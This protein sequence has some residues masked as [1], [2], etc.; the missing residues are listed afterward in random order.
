MKGTR[1][2]TEEQVTHAI[3]VLKAYAEGTLQTDQCDELDE[4]LIAAYFAW[5]RELADDS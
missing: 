5:E 4:A 1:T 3:A 2:M